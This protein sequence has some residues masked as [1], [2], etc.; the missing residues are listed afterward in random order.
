LV[1]GQRAIGRWALTASLMNSV[2]SAPRSASLA[3]LGADALREGRQHVSAAHP[4]LQVL[5]PPSGAITG[6]PL[7]PSRRLG[8]SVSSRAL[9]EVRYRTSASQGMG[10]A[11]GDAPVSTRKARAPWSITTALQWSQ[12]MPASLA[13]TRSKS[14]GAPS[15]VLHLAQ[16]GDELVLLGYQGC[17]VDRARACGYA[18]KRVVPGRPGKLAGAQ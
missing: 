12:A 2:A 3:G 5:A 11:A 14:M 6:N 13:P 15:G 9:A 18:G 17:E 16:L 10:G 7:R 8:T 1:P 4:A